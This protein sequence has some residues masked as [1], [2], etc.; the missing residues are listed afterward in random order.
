MDWHAEWFSACGNCQAR[1]ACKDD[2]DDDTKDDDT[3]DEETAPSIHPHPSVKQ[4]TASP[5][6]LQS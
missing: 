4:L 2:A 3:E 1:N 5:G 6:H